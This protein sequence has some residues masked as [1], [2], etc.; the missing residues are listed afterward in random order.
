MVTDHLL[1]LDESDV[2]L[3]WKKKAVKESASSA[4]GGKHI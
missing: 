4:F 2:D 1:T 3:A